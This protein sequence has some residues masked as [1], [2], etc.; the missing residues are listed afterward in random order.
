MVIEKLS[1]PPD[2]PDP[3]L[4]RSLAWRSGTR[5]VLVALLLLL[6]VPALVAAIGVPFLKINQFL[7]K[8]NAYSILRSIPA[9]WSEHAY[10]LAVITAL[11]LV[12]APL[13]CWCALFALWFRPHNGHDRLRWR[14]RLVALW[15]WSMID[16]FGLALLL[17]LTEGDDLIK[18]EIRQGLYLI[19]AAIV[20]LTVTYVLVMRA[21]RRALVSTAPNSP[22]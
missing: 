4:H 10:I 3:G 9:L 19:M 5:G 16:V 7:L 21:A 20:V 1:R 11:T 2:D 8:G 12:L 15:Q 13:L 22:E 18:T 6:S 17:F 14:R